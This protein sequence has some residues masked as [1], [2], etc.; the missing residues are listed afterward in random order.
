MF[1]FLIDTAYPPGYLSLAMFSPEKKI[2]I[3]QVEKFPNLL[4]SSVISIAF[5]NL[6]QKYQD[7]LQKSKKVFIAVST[8][9]GRFTGLRVGLSFAKTLS[10]IKDYPIYPMSSL[11]ILAESQFHQEQPVL[12]LMNA[13]KNSMFT[14]LY[15]KN[16]KKWD[17]LIPPCVLSPKQLNEKIETTCLCIGDGYERYSAILSS[18]IKEKISIKQKKTGSP[19][20]MASLLQKE[21]CSSYFIK[22]Q[23]LKPLYLKSPV[24]NIQNY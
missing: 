16:N 18:K 19:Y 15:K 23:D 21:F 11:K 22:W 20:D 14:A 10:F 7:Q 3:L 5:Q 12:V 2:K 1:C 6:Y 9:P 17:T 4:A 13:F 8:G 24:Q